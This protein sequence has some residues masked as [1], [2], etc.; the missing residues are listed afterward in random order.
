MA[1]V[2][3]SEGFPAIAGYEDVGERSFDDWFR[4]LYSQAY[5]VGFRILRDPTDAEDA[6]AETLA[7][8]LVAWGRIGAKPHLVA[9]VSRVAANVAIDIGRRRRRD[10]RIPVPAG[11]TG[12]EDDAVLGHLVTSDL[13]GQLPKRQREVVALRYLAD[14]DEAEVAR[15]LRISVGSVKT[16]AHRGLAA[17]REHHARTDG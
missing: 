14:L 16:H 5:K 17:L 9:W 8:T 11:P 6:A 3:T 10:R 15:C 1:I 7:R 4:P 12:M 2:S 13:L